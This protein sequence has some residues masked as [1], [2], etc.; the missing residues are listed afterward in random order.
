VRVFVGGIRYIVLNEVQKR[1]QIL[2]ET[3]KNQS[4]PLTAVQETFVLQFLVPAN[5]RKLTRAQLIR[6]MT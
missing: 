1:G 6:C 2:R 3:C 5:L 4:R